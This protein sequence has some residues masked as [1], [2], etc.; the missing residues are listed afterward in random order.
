MAKKKDRW[1]K[2]QVVFQPQVHLGMQV[3]MDKIINAVRPTLGPFP[4][5]VM[6]DTTV[7]S[8]GRLPEV[9]DDGGTIA[10]RI[11]QIHG[12]D[13][14]V[15]AMLIRNVLWRLREEVGDGTATAAVLFQ[16]VYHEGVRYL[17]SGGNAM[18]L[19]RFLE[20]GTEEIIAA[21]D[22]LAHQ[23]E[24]KEALTRLAT[25]L[26]RDP[27]LGKLFGEIFDIIGEYGRLEIRTS[28]SREYDREYVEG[29]YWEGGILSRAMVTDAARQRT[30]LENAAILMT[31]LSVEDPRELV[32]V[33]SLAVRANIENLL[34]IT[35]KMSETTLATILANK[36]QGRIKVNIV[37]AKTPGVG[38]DVQR[39]SLMDMAV[40]TGGRPL[41]KTA[42]ATL[43]E[44]Q[45]QDLGRARRVWVDRSFVGIIGG[46]GDPRVLRRHI[47]EL[48]AVFA[49]T[50]DPEEREKVQERIGKLLGGSA[51]LR[52][53][54]LTK[55]EQEFNKELAQ[56]T[57]DALRGAMREGVVP[58]GGAA[59]LACV[60]DLQARARQSEDGDEQAAYRILARAMQAP[61][62][63]LLENAGYDPSEVLAQLRGLPAG[64]GFD[65]LS[66][67]VVDMVEAGIV[68]V[69]TVVKAAVRSA[70]SGAAMALTT[71][72]L[73]HRANAPEALAT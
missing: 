47:A 52:V 28:D 6:Y 73:V 19:R 26:C 30:D 54:G 72:V 17:A 64:H 69:T 5:V 20:Q 16:S 43:R 8:T 37:A 13:A 36:K 53:G 41:Y 29:M 71:D 51:T 49:R 50:T 45:L 40:L 57:A 63:A 70:I 39:N 33:L 34:I 12:R 4:R 66:G 46:R 61:T 22:P 7:G 10:R 21:L 38:V 9:L 65:V 24:G 31:D 18:R 60:A 15:G 48:R 68:D 14:D 55:T 67:N 3:G 11:I 27:K 23:I 2:P 25:H 58:G 59:L 35:P 42:G 62:R 32:A 56:R 1:Q 44:V